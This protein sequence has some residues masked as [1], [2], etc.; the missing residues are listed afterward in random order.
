M[1]A[2][3]PPHECGLFP[4]GDSVNGTPTW[5]EGAKQTAVN[6]VWGV[7]PRMGGASSVSNPG[8]GDLYASHGRGDLE[9]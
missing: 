8:P 2:D 3:M 4:A 5:V 7:M 1:Q 6:A 9:D